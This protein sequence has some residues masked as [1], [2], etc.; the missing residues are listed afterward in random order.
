M[1]KALIS[2]LL[3]GIVI[4]LASCQKSNNSS[5]SSSAGEN[6][7]SS[8]ENVVSSEKT[9]SS[10]AS[11][12]AGS[13]FSSSSG[14]SSEDTSSVSS[15]LSSSSD[16]GA[17][18]LPDGWAGLVR[19][20]YRNDNANYAD[21][22]LWIWESG[23]EGREVVFD[24]LDKPDDFGIYKDIDL[25]AAPYQGKKIIALNFIVKF[26]GTWSGQSQDMNIVFNDYATTLETVGEKQRI[27]VYCTENVNG[28][29]NTYNTKKAALGDSI[30][31]AYF[32]DW[33]TI[34]IKGTGANDERPAEEVGLI[35]R[36]KLY[37]LPPSYFAAKKIYWSSLK[38][39]YLIKDESPASNSITVTLDND[40]DF[41]VTY[42][43]EAYFPPETESYKYT[44]VS[45]NRL[46]DEQKF[47][48]NYT[49]EGNDLGLSFDADNNPTF[50]LW[51]PS[52]SI[53]RLRLY[54]NPTPTTLGIEGNEGNDYYSP[55][56]MT[57]G[58]K[59]VWS[60]TPSAAQLTGFSYYTYSVFTGGQ[61]NETI[62]PYAY[63]SGI[64]GARSPILNP[65]ELAKTDPDGFRTSLDNLNT[66]APIDNA[67]DL[68]VYEVHVR[69]FTADETWI[70][71]KGYA[72][73]TYNAFVEEGTTYTKGGTT[74]S[75][76]FDSLKE[77]GVNAV[78]LLP[79]FDQANDERTYSKTVDGVSKLVSPK[80]NWGY[81]PQNYNL[82][83]G[84]YS[85]DPF[86]Y[87]TRIKE[88]KNL[89][90]KCADNGIRV[91]MDVVYNHMNAIN[92]N[93]FSKTM[94]GYF[95]KYDASGQAI[96]ETG[97]HNTFN[98][99]RKMGSKY[100][101]DSAA[102]WA[103]EY[104]IKGFRF[105][106]MGAIETSTMRGVKDKLY[107]VDPK[108]V[109]YGEGWRG[110]GESTNTQA[111]TYQVYRDLADNGKGS[112]GCFNDCGRD[113]LKGNTTY[114]S[115]APS[116]GFI[117]QGGTDLNE[118]TLYNAACVYLG[119]NRNI[120]NNT[121]PQ[122]TRPEQTVNYVSC[123]DN[124]T[125]YDQLN[126]CYNAGA[127]ADTDENSEVR[128]ASLATSAY[129]L[130]SQGIAFFQ[131]GEEIFRQKIMKPDDPNWDLIDANDYVTMSSGN[132]LIR[133]SYAFGDAVNSFKWDRKV[134]FYNEFL[135][136]KEAIQTR[137]QL[138]K[139]GVLGADYDT[140]IQGTFNDNGVTRKI[141]RLWDDL[142]AKGS[143]NSY[144]PILA[145][146][147][148]YSKIDASKKDVY[149]FLG[150]RMSGESA[151]IGCGNGT[152]KVLY[153]NMRTQG[154]LITVSG[155]SLTIYR[156]E[157]LIVEREA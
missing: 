25:T 149:V 17:T 46:F 27:T 43:L 1:K 103:K 42:Y 76:G 144:R 6:S 29:Y 74:V 120:T 101:V 51:A 155:N 146:Q 134:T 129:I 130:M 122:K 38:A 5:S 132:R 50:K 107:S 30:G 18:S 80:Y 57:K 35:S 68:T 94:P 75:T 100:V 95:F 11:S 12:A 154:S 53:V 145:A 90:K 59:G 91:I 20:Y 22:A 88:Y 96:D 55:L 33:R 128:E 98:T 142:V 147:T 9:S 124:Y 49:Y 39:K 93:P 116:Y 45:F 47:V 114:G 72:S 81:N 58:E 157:M 131:G 52:A 113:A 54:N 36:Y 87:A 19:F 66:T 143:D 48:D 110:S 106:L 16:S 111:G 133:N 137:K 8:S 151:T 79:V 121:T 125:L 23:G 148:Q 86:N 84:A 32:S 41:S 60:L 104:G 85:S 156:Y 140:Y 21:R 83:E 117:S 2:F 67:A 34:Q 63:A 31:S 139:D 138:V 99:A 135:K 24:N 118:N 78:Q 4:S 105:D 62:D 61:E 64:N 153:S 150:G 141:T 3:L 97:V 112:V 10:Q 15:S 70:S 7:T 73:G 152:L 89:I 126:Y 44:Y 65:T 77:L 92:D 13:S 26:Q 127:K 108:I 14:V 136:F 82:V 71:N 109:V 123:H 28:N 37:A 119:E 115:A 56:P 40:I 69:D 102:F